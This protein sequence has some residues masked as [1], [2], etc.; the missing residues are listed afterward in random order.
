MF[1]SFSM[2]SLFAPLIFGMLLLSVAF[3]FLKRKY[4]LAALLFLIGLIINHHF[5]CFPVNVKIKNTKGINPIRVMT[6]N[7]RGSKLNS[8]NMILRIADFV[9][10]ENPDVVF[11][12]EANDSCTPII[13]SLLKTCYQYSTCRENRMISVVYSKFPISSLDII[14]LPDY[15]LS[16]IYECIIHLPKDSVALYPCHLASNNYTPEKE[17][18]EA[19]SISTPGNLLNCFSNIKHASTIRKSH[20][21]LMC[22]KMDKSVHAIVLGDMNDVCGSAA[23]DKLEDAGLKDAW[24]EGGFGYGATIHHP[25]PFRIDHIYYSEGLKLISVKVVDSKGLSDHD[26]LVAEFEIR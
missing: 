19:D 1:I 25:L 3:S 17:Y 5:S 16:E 21:E 12:T 18:M 10:N 7:I 24:W 22:E 20:I 4:K 13:D 6:F 26:A 2:L 23:M 9:K 14:R 15:R 11:V 8:E